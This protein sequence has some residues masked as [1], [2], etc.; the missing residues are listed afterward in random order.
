MADGEPAAE[1]LERVPATLSRE[2]LDGVL[3]LPPRASAPM[4]VSSPGQ[5]IWAL[6]AEPRTATALAEELGGLF[7]APVEVVRADLAPILGALFDAG[8]IR[9]MGTREPDHGV[10][11]V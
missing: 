10:E 4:Q 2:L 6:L 9:V 7:D 1:R 11:Q 3:L 8:A 5:V